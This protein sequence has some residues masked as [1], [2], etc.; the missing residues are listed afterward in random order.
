MSEEGESWTIGDEVKQVILIKIP[1]F[2]LGAA[3]GLVIVWVALQFI[4]AATVDAL[5]NA[6]RG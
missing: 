6:S 2:I 3:I 4:P 1:I 5:S